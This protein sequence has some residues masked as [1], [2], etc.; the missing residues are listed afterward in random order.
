LDSANYAT[1]EKAQNQLTSLGFPVLPALHKALNN[2]PP[3]EAK[4][5]LEGLIRK[6]EANC[7][8]Q[9]L[10]LRRVLQILETSIEPQSASI[11]ERLATEGHEPE[12]IKASLQRLAEKKR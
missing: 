5:R 11:L 10:R 1:R 9:R 3:L 8:E 6:I 7:Q 12:M 2:K 4:M